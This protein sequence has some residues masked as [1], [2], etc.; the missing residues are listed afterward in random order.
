MSAGKINHLGNDGG[1]F[2]AS[3]VLGGGYFPGIVS[4]EYCNHHL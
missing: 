4:G 1:A 2:G 3:V